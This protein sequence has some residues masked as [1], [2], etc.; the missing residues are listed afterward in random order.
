MTEEHR[1]IICDSNSHNPDCPEKCKYCWAYHKTGEHECI[2]CGEIGKHFETM[3]PKSVDFVDC[4]IK[5]VNI[6]VIIVVNMANITK[7]IV[8]S[9][10]LDD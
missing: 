4:I 8:K 1:C 7:E 9:K 10:T 2:I 6:F 5:Q 3:C